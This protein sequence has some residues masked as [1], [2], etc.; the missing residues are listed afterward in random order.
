MVRVITQLYIK[1]ISE[2]P[3]R[4]L[5]P[6]GISTARRPTKAPPSPPKKIILSKAKD[7]A[8]AEG[9]TGVIYDVRCEDCTSHYVGQTGRR[10]AELVR[11]H[12]LAVGRPDQNCSNAQQVDRLN[13]SFNWETVSIL[14]RLSLET[15]GNSWKLGVQRD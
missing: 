5:Q 1:N 15:P 2:N 10:L 4:L 13:H 7:P 12:R 9:K 14:D 3:K 6:H 8:A 11:E